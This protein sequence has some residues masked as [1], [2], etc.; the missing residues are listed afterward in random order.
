MSRV[1]CLRPTEA[2]FGPTIDTLEHVS[3]HAPTSAAEAST[4]CA[5]STIACAAS[6]TVDSVSLFKMGFE[7]EAVGRALVETRGDAKAAFA[8]LRASATAELAASEPANAV[9]DEEEA[10]Q[11]ELALKMSLEPPEQSTQ[12]QSKTAC[13]SMTSANP[14]WAPPRYLPRADHLESGLRT[15]NL[16]EEVHVR[17]GGYCWQ[18]ATAFLDTGN[19]AMTLVSSAFAERH[20]I[21]KKESIPLLSGS[22]FGMAERWTTIRGV[23]PGSSTSAPV[24][25]IALKVRNQEMLLPAAVSDPGGRHDLL[26]GADV[27]GRLFEAGYR[28]GQGSM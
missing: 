27:I 9:N 17:D 7:T 13:C 19:Q 21:Y 20:A 10:R 25:T 2:H 8:I 14:L 16:I 6:A 18:R 22:S 15:L 24:V 12:R 11:L 5:T 23:V 28:L 26:L 3:A 4:N 1:A